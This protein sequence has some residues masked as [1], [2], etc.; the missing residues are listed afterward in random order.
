MQQERAADRPAP[1]PAN[2]NVDDKQVT[3]LLWLRQALN[4]QLCCRSATC[5][6]THGSIHLWKAT[7]CVCTCLV[8]HAFTHLREAPCVTDIRQQAGV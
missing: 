5:L 8:T 7:L 4:T 1:I 2:T 6:V 3:D